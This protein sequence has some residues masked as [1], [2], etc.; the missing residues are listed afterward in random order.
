MQPQPVYNQPVM[1]PVYGQ[2]YQ[3][4]YQQPGYY[5]QQQQQQPI[6]IQTWIWLVSFYLFV[7][8]DCKFKIKTNLCI[9]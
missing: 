4:P 7:L 3:Q 8:I 9:K 2:P 5:P 1:Q 6:I